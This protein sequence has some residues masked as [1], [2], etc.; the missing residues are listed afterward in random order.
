MAAGDGGPLRELAP[1]VEAQLA[2]GGAPTAYV[3]EAHACKEPL[4]DP[5]ALAALLA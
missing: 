2:R 5:A 3:C 4:T 1:Y